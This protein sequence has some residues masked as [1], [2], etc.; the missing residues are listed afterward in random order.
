MKR[1]AVIFLIALAGG[2]AAIG[3]YRL[4]DRRS[5][6]VHA[7]I[8]V[9][10][11]VMPASLTSSPGMNLPDFEAAA[12]LSVHAVVHIRSQFQRKSMVYDDFFEFFNWERPTPRERIFPYE[13]VGSGVIISP[14]GYI[15][16]NN[17]VVQEASEITVMLNDRRVFE[18]EVVG[19]DPSTDIALVKIDQQELP[20]LTFGNSDDLRIGEWVLAVGN[21]FSLTSTVTAGIVSAKARNINILGS[22]GAIE[23]FIQ[24]DAAINPGNSGGA[25]V[26][27]RGELVGINAA[28]ASG[29]GYYQGYSFAIPANIAHKVVE[30]FMKYG[31]IQRA[32]LG[33]YYR[34]VDD[35]FAK[36]LDMEFPR[37]IYVEEVIGGGSAARG[38]LNK[39][40]VILRMGAAEVNSKS[41]LTEFMGQHSP[42]ETI[43]VMVLRNGKTVELNI[44]LQSEEA[45][46]A[47]VQEDKVLIHGATFQP[48]SASEKEK[49]GTDY[50]FRIIRLEPGKLMNAGIKEGF[51]LLAIDREPVRSAAD[52]KNALTNRRGGILLEGVYPNGLR[53]YYGIGL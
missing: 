13:A 10:I 37:G 24:T 39:G 14:D 43:P 44:N 52:L 35:E 16:T 51:I 36:E 20:F 22:Q 53:A 48:L 3:L 23:S 47:V 8:P 34:E 12:E 6:E 41:E 25:L 40:D 17:H 7:N 31:K 45:T 30:D 21:P 28:I 2:V 5:P 1:I 4:I 33:I 26:N 9:P 11:P 27:T 49:L 50:G 18:A 38:G 15:V 29:T 19:T 42:G 46:V 32:Y